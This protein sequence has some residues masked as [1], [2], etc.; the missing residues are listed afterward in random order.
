MLWKNR[1]FLLLMTGEVV[2]GAGLWIFI[3]ANLQFMQGLIPSDTLKALVLMCG[4]LASI[5][6]SPKA[7]VVIDTCDK[8]KIMIISSW[9]RVLSPILMFPALAYDSLLWMIVA[10]VVMQS[11]A[12]FYFPT[13]QSSLPAILSKDELLKANSAYLNISTLS[14][15]CGTA[16]GGVLVASMELFHLYLFSLLA[17]AVL[18][19]ITLFVH[20]PH[21]ASRPGKEKVEFRE[22]LTIS[23]KD[24]AVM[25]SLVN[26]GFITLFL[27]GVNLM[28]VNFSEIQ[29][30]PQLMGWIFAA[31]G[32]SILVGGLL[33]KRWVGGRN[34]VTASTWMLFFFSLSQYGM[35]FAESRV[36]VLSSFAFFGLIVAFFFPVTTT[37][38]QKRLAHNQHGRFF[39]FKSMLD[40][41]FF[42]VALGIT[43]VCLDLLGVSGYLLCVATVTLL[44]GIFTLFYSRRHKLDVRATDDSP[45]AV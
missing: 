30:E 27:G 16:V 34:L 14:R 15:I 38:F 12:A 20:I 21:V 4:L 11:S 36:M 35:S 28:I 23:R 6:L 18:A 1:T 37:I 24:P 5:L 25:V 10:L 39:S 40:R 42:L 45:A 22:V 26:T 31:E 44:T 32:T 29:G 33:A 2:A 9:V 41:C 43:G 19:V 8:R 3:I 13:I 17:Y 7:G